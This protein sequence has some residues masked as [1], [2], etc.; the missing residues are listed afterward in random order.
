MGDLW[1]FVSNIFGFSLAIL[2]VFYVI[3]LSRILNYLKKEDVK[4]S[5]DNF[6]EEAIQ[7]LKDEG[8]WYGLPNVVMMKGDRNMHQNM[9][10]SERAEIQRRK[11]QEQIVKVEH[12]GSSRRFQLKQ[13]MSRNQSERGSRSSSTMSNTYW[14][15]DSS[16]CSSHR[17]SDC[18]SNSGSDGSGCD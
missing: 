3:R 4:E 17:D 10:P 5:N 6:R 8:K 14:F 13:M 15:I 12:G 7:Y 1:E 2:L 9:T 16:S 18:H 11:L